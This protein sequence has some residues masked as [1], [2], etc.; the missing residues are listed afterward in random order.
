MTECT[1]GGTDEDEEHGDPALRKK[2][3]EREGRKGG[4]SELELN[5]RGPSFAS[6][7]CQRA[8]D[9]WFEGCPVEFARDPVY[10]DNSVG[11]ESLPELVPPC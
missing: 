10:C 3:G 2:R 1:L 11:S 9:N 5:R 7:D 8:S 4:N 6:T